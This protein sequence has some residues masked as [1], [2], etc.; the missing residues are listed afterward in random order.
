MNSIAVLGGNGFVGRKICEIG[1]RQ[2]W[3]V[4]SLSRSGTPPKPLSHMDNSWISQVKWEKANLLEPESYKGKLLGKT[5][6]VH[7]VG[8]LF[9]NSDYKTSINSNFNFLNDIQK[10]ANSLKGSNPMARNATN[11]YASIQR[12]S[13]VI[14][15]DTYL[16]VNKTDDA[17]SKLPSFVYISAD[18]KPPIVPEAYLTTK[19]EAE[20]ELSCKKN[21]RSIFMRPNFMYD[22]NEPISNNRRILSQIIDLGYTAKN[23]VFSDKIAALNSLVRPPVSTEKVALKVFEKLQDEN[24][25]G[26]V[27]LEEILK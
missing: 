18:A 13:A 8:I 16:D 6:V 2:G 4:T 19:R 10:L 21:L 14:L 22:A 9:E 27:G 25:Q 7:S 15:A 1:V 23:L 17:I 3:S 5:A 12:D 26:V 20:F 24:F 11:T